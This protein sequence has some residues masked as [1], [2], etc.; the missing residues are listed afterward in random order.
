MSDS[1]YLWRRAKRWEPIVQIKEQVSMA[2]V[3]Y[4]ILSGDKKRDG[5]VPPY[6]PLQRCAH[7]AKVYSSNIYCEYYR[8]TP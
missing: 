6:R 8:M 3:A 7:A 5:Q 4:M 1:P 2:S